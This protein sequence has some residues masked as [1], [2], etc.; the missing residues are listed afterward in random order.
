MR[1]I[2]IFTAL[3][4]IVIVKT[5][6]AQPKSEFKFCHLTTEK[7]SIADLESCPL[8]S[9]DNEENVK[10]LSFVL[11]Y[12]TKGIATEKK[13]E[14]NTIPENIITEL[15]ATKS[16]KKIQVKKIVSVF[17]EKETVTDGPSYIIS[18]KSWKRRGHSKF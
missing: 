1:K 16:L 14:G 12:E 8:V 3:I 10:I 13:I 11:S 7:I 2:L 17:N 6:F 15:K 9:I 5:S 4:F 18:K